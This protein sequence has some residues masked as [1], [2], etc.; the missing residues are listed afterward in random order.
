MAATPFDRAER[1]RSGILVRCGRGVRVCL[2]LATAAAILGLIGAGLLYLRLQQGPLPVPMVADLVASRV[3]ARI[4]D[5]RVAVGGAEFSLARAGAPAGLRFTDVTVT[6]PD[7]GLLMA[8]PRLAAR[9]VLGDLLR[10]RVQ[11]TEIVLIGARARV[12]RGRDGRFRFGLGTGPGVELAGGDGE[13]EA[14]PAVSGADAVAEIVSSFV[15]DSP[16]VP[17]LERLRRI[18]ILRADLTYADARTGRVWRTR[19]SDLRIERT[20]DGARASIEASISDRAGPGGQRTRLSIGA[21]RRRGTGRTDFRLGLRRLR[22]ADLAGQVDSL[23]WLAALDAPLDGTLAVSVLGDGRFGP[24]SGALSARGGTVTLGEEAARPFER[25]EIGFEAPRGPQEVE[26]KTLTLVSPALTLALSGRVSAATGD[27]LV[28]GPVDVALALDALRIDEPALFEAPVAFDEGQ[29][30]ARIVPEPARIEIGSA[31]LTEGDLTLAAS[32]TLARGE[33]GWRADLRTTGTGLTVAGLKALWPVPAAANARAWVVE[34][35]VSGAIPELLGQFRFGGGAPVVSLDFRFEELVSRYLGDMSPITGA[36]GTG[37]LGLDDFW[38]AMEAGAVA[39]PGRT[40]I[41]LAG[42]EVHISDLWGEVTWGDIVVRGEGRLGS[43]LGLI[44]EP[45]LA[46]VRRLG[47]D[48]AAVRGESTVTATLRLPLL[49]ALLIEDVAVSADADLRDVNLTLPLS[50]TPT[51]VVADRLALSAD[52]RQMRIRG[53]ATVAGT[54]L[55]IDWQELYGEGDGRREVAI[56]GRITPE[57]LAARGLAVEAFRSGSAPLRLSLSGA[58]DVATL[59]GRVDLGP[60]A[61]GLEALRWTKPEGAPGSLTVEGRIGDIGDGAVI[62]ALALTAPGLEVTGTARLDDTGGLV[63]AEIAR[64]RLEER[65]DLALTLARAADGVLDIRIDAALLDL[66]DFI[67]RPTDSET[68]G[69]PPIR[70]EA[71]IAELRLTPKLRIAPASGFL[72][73]T[74]EGATKLELEGTA[75]GQAPFA[76]TYAR[77]SGEPA[78]VELRS[79]DAGRLL[80]AL[81]LFTGA[82]GGTLRLDARLEPDAETDASGTV[83]IDGVVVQSDGTFGS[84][85]E[86]GGVTEAAEAVQEGGIAFDSIEIPF[87]YAGGRMTLGSSIARS[88]MLA[89]KVEGTVDETSDEVALTGVISPAYALTGALDEIPVLGAILSGGRGEGILAMTFQVRGSLEDPAFSV[90]PLSILTPGFLRGV[91]SGRTGEPDAGFLNQ[92][93]P[94]E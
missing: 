5:A 77:R 72:I 25:F 39:P 21:T 32:G 70:L 50:G 81:G 28:P 76:A 47:L 87:S 61:L 65:A 12:E 19:G 94:T 73:R 37:H 9:F 59:S 89:V 4:E 22:P 46:L 17:V 11:P 90:N 38:L 93:G 7:G 18:G 30:L 55:G 68:A 42:S 56:E 91:F 69:S 40:P 31:H 29:L 85:L 1:R 14:A 16:P 92:L 75:G 71:E 49:A 84:I 27:L 88:N 52:T 78:L 15:G 10:G 74:S 63:S 64:L 20:E 60:A 53:R 24:L 2:R 33:D 51:E 43:V 3:N 23:A 54:P 36:R 67:D 6:G 79:E 66:S 26:L 45:P 58:G 83:R 13:Q 8:A 35:L 62:D 82:R 86:E 48:P 80:G 57:L 34:H 41:A 44:D